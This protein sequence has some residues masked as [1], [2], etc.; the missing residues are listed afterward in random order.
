MR[1][2][3]EL[4]GIGR[5]LFEGDAKSASRIMMKDNVPGLIELIFS[6]DWCQIPILVPFDYVGQIVFI[7]STDYYRN[8]Y[9]V[10]FDYVGQPTKSK[11]SVLPRCIKYMF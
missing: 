1:D 7:F 6:T 11:G 9:S 5:L 3:T 4:V 10:L 8:I 2:A